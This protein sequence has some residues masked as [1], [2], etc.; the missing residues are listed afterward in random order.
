MTSD[1]MRMRYLGPLSLAGSLLFAGLANASSGGTTG[2]AQQA[3]GREA[4]PELLA[5]PGASGEP[6][7]DDGAQEPSLAERWK[8]V[9][10]FGLEALTPEVTGA[11]LSEAQSKGLREIE[12]DV[13]YW[14]GHYAFFHEGPEAAHLHW[15]F[16]TELE[17]DEA[18]RPHISRAHNSIGLIY[19]VQG[20]WITARDH[21]RLALQLAAPSQR[22]EPRV[23]LANAEIQLGEWRSAVRSYARALEQ[24]TARE[25][26]ACL[27]GLADVYLEVGLL[28]AARA[29]L[30]AAQALIDDPVSREAG[31][32]GPWAQYALDE[33]AC[34]LLLGAGAFRAAEDAL[35]DMRREVPYEELSWASRQAFA[36]MLAELA[37]RTGRPEH[38]ISTLDENRLLISE[39]PPTPS[40]WLTRTRAHIAL[41]E[42]ES[43]WEAIELCDPGQMCSQSQG[44]EDYWTLFGTVAE[45]TDRDEQ[46]ALAAR[47]IKQARQYGAQLTRDD[48][49]ATFSLPGL[50]PFVGHLAIPESDSAADEVA[51]EPV[52]AQDEPAGDRA[53]DAVAEVAPET[54]PG[55]TD[56]GRLWLLNGAGLA[57]LLLVSVSWWVQLRRSRELDRLQAALDALED[58][59]LD[60]SSQ[61]ERRDASQQA[62]EATLELL[63]LG[64]ER[65]WVAPNWGGAEGDV[66]RMLELAA[67]CLR[68]HRGQFDERRTSKNPSDVARALLAVAR[69]SEGLAL[70]RGVALRFAKPNGPVVWDIGDGDLARLLE[71][72]LLL[73]IEACLPEGC[74]LFEWYDEGSTSSLSV[75]SDTA[76]P[77]AE[78]PIAEELARGLAHGA[79]QRPTAPEGGG[80]A[81]A[82]LRVAVLQRVVQSR[83]GSLAMD[84]SAGGWRLR[85]TW[86]TPAAGST[87]PGKA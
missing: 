32:L 48:L 16:L 27:N 86:P 13:R 59:R 6:G 7:A 15:R 80:V 54:P 83:G 20:D 39:F 82:D 25:A 61:R 2:E 62:L 28:D 41:E 63:D 46:A 74:L 26:F 3:E 55:E 49:R 19:M 37:L 38:A 24:P 71:R 78:G 81:L 21:Y 8:A 29:L 60:G 68:L 31:D 34:R 43:A 47:R 84:T 67:D 40:E 76:A 50:A 1:T 53:P 65:P 79:E 58:A 42:W 22:N 23:N 30:R 87:R 51:G 45:A 70:E 52:V 75:Q 10:D 64:F 35:E 66:D 18:T 4:T 36:E 44:F 9:Y 72:L 56:D 77:L 73:S 57:A 85:L 14:A 12:L 11:I 33:K 69:S 17:P 5:E